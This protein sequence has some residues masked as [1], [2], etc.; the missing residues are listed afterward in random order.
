[1]G[2]ALRLPLKLIPSRTIVH[3]LRGP[4]K[5]AR[6]IARS[7][8]AGCWLGSYEIKFQQLLAQSLGPGGCFFDIGANVGFY[9]LLASRLIG[10]DGCVVSFEPNPRNL[11]FLRRHLTLNRLENVQ[12]METAVS[13][14]SGQRM[15]SRKEGPAQGH[16]SDTGDLH[17]RVVRLDDIIEDGALPAPDAMKIDIEGAELPALQGARR[18]LGRKH[19]LIFLATHGYRNHQACCALLVEAG[20]DVEEIVS[21]RSASGFREVVARPRSQL[22]AKETNTRREL[23]D[24]VHR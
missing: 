21:P 3:V 19:P 10:D 24:G 14:I 17:V 22:R 1:M 6:W 5:G 23:I 20:Y 13:N 9:T 12:V 7:S 18:L 4:L 11:S 8:S 2:R 16:L 15:F